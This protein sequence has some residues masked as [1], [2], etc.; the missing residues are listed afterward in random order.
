M[1]L[2]KPQANF[3]LK[4]SCSACISTLYAIRRGYY[5]MAVVPGGVFI[6]S[7]N[8]WRNPRYNSWER[9]VDMIFV[10]SAFT[11]QCIRA[12]RSQNARLYY[13]AMLAT[14][15][16]YPMGKYFNVKGKY[17]ISAY[18]HGMLHILANLSCILLYSGKID[19]MF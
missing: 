19:P 13:M 6:T 18:L 1:V 4:T 11:Y 7:V 3:L 9:N 15:L 16:F 5:G 2:P 8:Y 14:V 12:Y 17:W 10:C